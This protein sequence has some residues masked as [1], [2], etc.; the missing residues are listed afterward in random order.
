MRALH[1]LRKNSKRAFLYLSDSFI[2]YLV[3]PYLRVKEARRMREALLLSHLEKFIILYYQVYKKYPKSVLDLSKGLAPYGFEK[4][5]NKFFTKFF[6]KMKISQKGITAIS[7]SYGTNGYMKSNIDIDIALISKDEADAYK[8]FVREYHNFWKNFFDPIGIM[9]KFT[10][11]KKLHVKTHILPLIN[12]SMYNTL[13]DFIGGRPTAIPKSSEIK[14]DIFVL[15]FK[16]ND[17]V[18]K[19]LAKN[20]GRKLPEIKTLTKMIGNYMELHMMDSRPMVDFNS[21]YM[22]NRFMRRRRSVYAMATFLAWALFS[23]HKSNNSDKKRV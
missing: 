7:S 6:N 5:H 12:T 13:L 22:L 14:E 9:L 2:R 16:I 20:F 11:N 1:P 17:K 23:S 4:E 15:S 18:K 19:E 8:K 21:G 10:N 3:G